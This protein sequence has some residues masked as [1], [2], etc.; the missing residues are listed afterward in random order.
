MA[1]L[2]ARA[3]G[4][5]KIVGL[6]RKSDKREDALRLGCDEYV[7]TAEEP[8]WTHKHA[9]SLDLII[10]TVSS[11]R[12]LNIA[13]YLALLKRDGTFVQLGNPDDGPLTVP[14]HLLIMQRLRIAGSV[15]GSPKEIR[16]MLQLVVD[17]NVRPWIEQRPMSEANQ[18][19]VDLQDGKPRYRYVLVNDWSE[20]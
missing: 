11:A 19:I 2:F 8:G 17:K 1:V 13:D 9:R 5:R 7:A 12:G 4:A 18:T 15:I 6:S 20:K 10:S 14:Q 16:D 3:L